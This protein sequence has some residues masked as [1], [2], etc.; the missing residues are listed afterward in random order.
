MSWLEKTPRCR[1]DGLLERSMGDELVIYD[2]ESHRAHALEPPAREVWRASDGRT[3]VREMVRRIGERGATPGGD[4]EDV[5][6]RC[7]RLLDDAGLFETPLRLP[8]PSRVT[9]RRLLRAA[10]V[11]P[12]VASVAVPEPAAAQSNRPFGAPCT[13]SDQC[14]SGCCGPSGKCKM[15]GACI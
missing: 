1:T 15:F 14:A 9:R 10:A 7:L 5:V 13:S 11:A 3:S 2:T 8:D 6:V 12:L 4:P